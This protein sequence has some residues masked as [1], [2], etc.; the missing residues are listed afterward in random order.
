MTNGLF[1]RKV[2]TD[3]MHW[4]EDPQRKPLVIRG[5]RQVGKS[6]V[7][8]LFS[9]QYRRYAELNL[10]KTAHA[11]LFRGGLSVTELI[12]AIQLECSVPAGKEPWLLFLDEIQEVPEAVAILRFFYE[13]RPDIHVI[14]AGSLLETALDA[15]AISFPVGRVQFLHMR[16]LNFD[17][18]LVAMEEDAASE[19]FRTVPV[20]VFAHARLLTLFHT[21]A[22]VG[23][24][25]EAVL[26]YRQTG[27]D[28]AAVN[29][30]YADLVS[31][32]RDDISK[33]GRN[34]TMRRVLLHCLATAPF[35]IGSR[36]T[37][38]GFG[39][40]NYQ[41]REVG[42]ALRT[43][44]RA[45]LLELVYPTV[46]GQEPLMP[47]HK[48]APRLQFLDAGLVNHVAGLQRQLIGVRDLTSVYRG[49]LIEQVVGQEIKAMDGR[50]DVPLVFW[51]RDKAQAQAEVDFLLQTD[52]GVIPVEAKSGATG[53]LRSLHEFIAR[54]GARLAVR[55]YAGEYVE[56]PIQ[57]ADSTCLLINI[58]YYA[59]GFIPQ[60]IKKSGHPGIE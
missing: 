28:L 21:Y 4:K 49:R 3:L 10:E 6:S 9:R 11:A 20:P 39:G 31:A 24:M 47:D 30:V 37:F 35:Q 1:K 48:K 50:R 41:S 40:S 23:G 26:R 44:E 27:G 32:F 7:V 51:V 5:A 33:Y 15:A 29:G 36:I 17:E 52:A 60:Y 16:P 42:E 25:P 57:V 22:L 18:F 54:N 59:A 8:R 56:H 43:L 13:E 53:K 46:H 38:N 58:P 2:L 34:E 45:K 55:L 19:V 14:A 12:Q